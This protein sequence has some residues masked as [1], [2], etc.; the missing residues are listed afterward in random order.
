MTTTDEPATRA[1]ADLTT[2]LDAPSLS[3]RDAADRLVDAVEQA[4]LPW[5]FVP[6]DSLAGTDVVPVG[7]RSWPVTLP[8]GRLHGVVLREPGPSAHDQ[9]VTALLSMVRSLADVE[10]ALAEAAGRLALAEQQ[11][12][13]DPMTGLLNRRAWEEAIAAEI[14]RMRRHESVAAVV[15]I[16][17]DGL[18]ETNDTDGHLMGDLLIRRAAVAIRDAVREEDVVAR[19]GGDEFA[20]LAVEAESPV[21]DSVL[22]RIRAA[23][24]AV[25]VSASAGAAAARGPDESLEEAITRADSAMY[26]EK[27]RHRAARAR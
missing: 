21:P 23:L 3:C 27:R 18:K 20:V 13:I 8:G 10:Q 6:A 5:H 22:F 9:L 17:I 7:Y 4:G 15:V 16:D 14:A 12:R 19:T 24:K 25:D 26:A 1:A 2:E 11:A